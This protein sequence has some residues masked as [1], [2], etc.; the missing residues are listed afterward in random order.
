MKKKTLLN[1]CLATLLSLTSVSAMAEIITS[2]AYVRAVP[3]GFENTALF[4]KITNRNNSDV[5]LTKAVSSIADNVELH[6]H[7]NND[8][9]MMMRPVEQIKI[10]GT[11]TVELAP[12]GY[13]IML[14]DLKRDLE[15][16]ENIEVDL[17]F[18]DGTKVELE[19][20]V[21]KVIDGL[22]SHHHH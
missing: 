5:Y 8:G 22:H 10:G 20:P 15:V 16:G 9:A 12:G 3:A 14:I 1:T 19:A 21:K 18:S 2:D 7:V 6:N 11:Q 13:H 17:S 4:V